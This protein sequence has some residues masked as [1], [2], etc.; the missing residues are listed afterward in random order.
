MLKA[1]KNLL[2]EYII[3]GSGEGKKR[4]AGNVDRN[5]GM[6]VCGGKGEATG[7]ERNKK[8]REMKKGTDIDKI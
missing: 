1:L 8:I 4:I 7:L 5:C 2:R 6:G 3:A